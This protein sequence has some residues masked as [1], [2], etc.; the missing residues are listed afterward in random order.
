MAG[1]DRFPPLQ[2]ESRLHLFISTLRKV[3][4]RILELTPV[5]LA[6]TPRPIL[7]LLVVVVAGGNKP[8]A[9]AAAGF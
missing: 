8:E 3:G 7:L 2:T 6:N 5:H 4:Y 1:L 9:A